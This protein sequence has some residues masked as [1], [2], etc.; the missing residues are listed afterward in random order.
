MN[1]PANI[2][3]LIVEY[4]KS[5][6]K[7]ITDPVLLQWYS[8]SDENRKE[9]MRYKKIWLAGNTFPS[10]D[11]FDVQAAWRKI[12]RI[13][14]RRENRSARLRSLGYAAGGIAAA[15]VLVAVIS[16][17]GLWGA[18]EDLKPVHVATEYGNHSRIVLPDGTN[19]LLNAGSRLDF[20][21]SKRKKTREVDFSGEAFFEVNSSNTPFVINTPRGMQVTVTGTKFNLSAY[22]DDNKVRTTLFEGSVQL[23]G[24]GGAVALASGDMA[25]F[26]CESGSFE[27]S[28]N[29]P[30]AH[31][32]GWM[33]KKLYMDNTSLSEICRTLERWYDV[34]I[35]VPE[36]LGKEITYTGVIQEDSVADIMNAMNQLS[37]INY[38]IDG[39]HITIMPR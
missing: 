7:E 13:H 32:N 33:E 4:F 34:K 22:S 20:R 25:A 27:V 5:G 10:S 14:N 2:G 31:S 37:G 26:D 9:L 18:G 3:D 30:L 8:G 36:K 39:N 28:H 15:V 6:S 21:Y 16:W 29:V 35:T 24:A 19:V 17:A 38:K 11:E 12:D 1:I 23:Q